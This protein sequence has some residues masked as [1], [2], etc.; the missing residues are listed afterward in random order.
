MLAYFETWGIS[1]L[2]CHSGGSGMVVAYELCCTAASTEYYT[3]DN[4]SGMHG[5]CL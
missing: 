5:G 3:G 2:A 4:A 1:A